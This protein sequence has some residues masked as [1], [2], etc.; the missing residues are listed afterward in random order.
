MEFLK[1]KYLFLI[2]VIAISCNRNQKTENSYYKNGNLEYN[3]TY[4]NDTT[5]V[6]L[7]YYES[8]ILKDSMTLVN[9]KKY[10]RVK[11][12]YPNG[13]TKSDCYYVNDLTNGPCKMY[14][15]SG[16]LEK[17]GMFKDSLKIGNYFEYYD[18]PGA[19]L[20]YVGNY[21]IVKGK[22]WFNWGSWFDEMGKKTKGTVR[23]DT[24]IGP[25]S[26]MMRDSFQLIIRTSNLQLPK[27]RVQ[28]GDFDENFY[29]STDST[30]MSFESRDSTIFIGAKATR[31]GKQTIRGIVEN[32]EIVEKHK[33]GRYKTK[34]KDIYWSYDYEVIQ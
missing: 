27:V 2:F 25:K 26:V 22:Q 1:A 10:G 32:Y 33:D 6:V 28:I 19:K 21:K 23:I 9:K 13:N 16:Y 24:I 15:I 30:L 12:F 8:G 29:L 4:L 11:E 17:E 14:Y 18:L 5:A 7:Y 20:R 31:I 3:L 34:S